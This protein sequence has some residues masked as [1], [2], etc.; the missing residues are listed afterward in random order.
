[1][2]ETVKVEMNVPKEAKEIVDFV[3]ALLADALAKKPI[4]VIA[5]DVLPKLMSAID[6]YSGVADELKSEHKKELAAYLVMQ[7]M[8]ALEKKAADVPPAA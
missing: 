4:A 6:G 1:M 5:A 7:V 8:D 2:V 3:A